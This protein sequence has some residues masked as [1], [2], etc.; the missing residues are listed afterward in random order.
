MTSAGQLG[1]AQAGVRIDRAVAQIGRRAMPV[2]LYGRMT[3]AL[4]RPHQ[5]EAALGVAIKPLSG[6]V[7][8]S[9]GVERRVAL[10]STGR[11]AF[12]LIA[13][14]GLNPTRIAGPLITEGYAQAG[15]VGF[16]RHD[17]F[18]DG[19]LSL[20]LPL[21]NAER[22]RAGIAL[23]GGAQPGVSRLDIGPMIETRLPLG[24]AQPRLVVEWRQRVAGEARPGSGPSVTL[25]SDF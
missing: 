21:D 5:P 11:N 16:A 8:L 22:T 4:S 15:M 7:P 2:L 3:A 24:S 17:L 10:D 19:R 6:R 14:G 12:A 9:I 25:A 20:G 1:G 18:V 23:S 13:A